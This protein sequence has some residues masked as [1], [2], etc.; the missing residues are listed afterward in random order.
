MSYTREQ[1]ISIVEGARQE[2]RR[3]ASKFFQERL[4]G[5]DQYACGFAWVTVFEKGS[6]RLGRALI[7]AGFRKSYRGGLELWNPS[8]LHVQNVDTLAAGAEAAAEYL[9]QALGV[10]AYADSRLD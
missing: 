5:R 10:K 1:V 9:E 3:A 4:G 6:T 7:E 8:G 2:A